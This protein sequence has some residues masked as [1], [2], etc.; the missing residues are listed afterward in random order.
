MHPEGFPGALGRRRTIAR[1]AEISGVGLHSGAEVTLRIEPGVPGQGIIFERRDLSR[2]RVAATLEAVAAT[3]RRTTLRVGAER[4]DTVEHLLAAVYAAE[5]DDL[6]IGLDGPEVPILDGSFAPF[7]ELLAEA[8]VVEL[9]GRRVSLQLHGSVEVT[10]GEA[11]YHLSPARGLSVDLTLDYVEPVIGRQRVTWDIDRDIFQR[12]IGPARTFGF[13]EEVEPLKQR[14]LLGGA[15]MD[16]AMV[17]SPVAVLNTTPRWP[18]EF[19]RHKV[20]DLVGDLAL[21]GARLQCRV[22]AHRPSHRGNLACARALRRAGTI[23]E[24]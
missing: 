4:V 6:T 13:L 18:D 3:E 14:G 17:L 24:E 7:V 22:V 2:R 9:T 1:P 8:G 20:G 23:T 15:T 16:C 12:E 21:L 11:R 5:I 10:E 19:A